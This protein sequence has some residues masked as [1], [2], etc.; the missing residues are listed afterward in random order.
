MG[1]LCSFEDAKLALP[2][3]FFMPYIQLA[4]PC[5]VIVFQET[6]FCFIL[7]ACN[8]RQFLEFLMNRFNFCQSAVVSSGIIQDTMPVNLSTVST[9]SPAEIAD[10]VCTMCHT[11]HGPQ[12]HLSRLRSRSCH[13]GIPSVGSG[14]LFHDTEVFGYRTNLRQVTAP[15]TVFQEV[16]LVVRIQTI[17]K[18]RIR[19]ICDE[20]QTL[21]C[22]S[23]VVQVA[24]Q[25]VGGDKITR[26]DVF[27]N[28]IA[29]QFCEFACAVR[30]E[31][32]IIQY[33]MRVSVVAQSGSR[34]IH[35]LK[36]VVCL[37][38]EVGSPC[39]VQCINASVF[40][41]QEF[42][43]SDSITL[44]I[45]LIFL[46]VDL[47]VNLPSDDCR[48]F[49]IMRCR[50][51]HNNSGQF[52]VFRRVV[53]VMSSSA[54]TVQNTVHVCIQNFRIFL[55]QP[56]RRRSCRGTKDHFHTH[57]SSYIQKS[58]KEIIVEYTFVPLDLAPCKFCDS[59]YFDAVFQHSFQVVTPETFVP[60]FRI[61]TSPQYQSF[62][63]NDLH[64]FL[65]FSIIYIY[66]NICCRRKCKEPYNRLFFHC[67]RCQ[68]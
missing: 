36:A 51:F 11:L 10:I 56:G 46:T 43:E 22:H 21:V 2:L 6:N 68:T 4:V 7:G 25:T 39:F 23:L 67:T 54:M 38:P 58:V 15:H 60:V 61:I 57:I 20:I 42:A 53:V 65:S 50:F 59:D 49:C 44:R 19:I 40:F 14:L 16:I 26:F 37:I 13:T 63:I 12:G 8:L 17:S 62:T 28:D 24:E 47:I 30:Y 45:E 9:G 31:S 48:M 34:H 41:H 5:V 1:S 35:F 55:G 66:D 3:Y 64:K 33:F 52:L 18:V 32:G 29:L 27:A